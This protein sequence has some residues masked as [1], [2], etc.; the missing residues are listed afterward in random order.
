[1]RASPGSLAL[2]SAQPRVGSSLVAVLTDPDGVVGEAEWVWHRSTNPNPVFETSW[3]VVSAAT[4]SSYTPVE[5]DLGYY[6]RV[7]VVYDDGHGPGKKR[8]VVSQGE[9]VEFPGPS[10][11]EAKV[12]S[13][14]ASGLSVVRGI[15]E[16]ANA[17]GKVGDSVV[18]ES[19]NGNVF[20][21]TLS[22]EDAALFAIDAR[23]GAD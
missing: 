17:G 6:F 11:P 1:M 16:T 18:A 15:A 4:T 22:G 19:P 12:N 2:S 20:T 10:F 8:Q 23:Y 21:Y 7:T 13:G 5:V 14:R 9:V 3:Q